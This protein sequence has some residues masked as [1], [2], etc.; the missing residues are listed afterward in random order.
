MGG[1]YRLGKSA[2][3]MIILLI[4]PFCHL[5]CVFLTQIN[6][7][8]IQSRHTLNGRDRGLVELLSQT[9]LEFKALHPIRCR[10]LIAGW[11]GRVFEDN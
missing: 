8:P 3:Q 1:A 6:S 11:I 4:D 2:H 5:S 10:V 7:S 9:A